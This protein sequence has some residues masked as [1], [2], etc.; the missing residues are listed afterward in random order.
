[1]TSGARRPKPR[2]AA[3]EPCSG[4]HIGGQASGPRKYVSTV[5]AF[6]CVRMRTHA[7][8]SSRAR[9]QTVGRRFTL[10][11]IKVGHKLFAVSGFKNVSPTKA[12][13]SFA[14]EVGA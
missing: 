10:R 7:F 5:G 1:M 9:A 4:G 8:V 12:R 3:S 13:R 6:R 2:C 14:N 11:S